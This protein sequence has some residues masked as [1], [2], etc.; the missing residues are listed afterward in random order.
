MAVF[1]TVCRPILVPKDSKGLGLPGLDASCRPSGDRRES[2]QPETRNQ[3]AYIFR[4]GQPCAKHDHDGRKSG[5][6]DAFAAAAEARMTDWAIAATP[7]RWRRWLL[8]ETPQSRLQ[9]R[10]SRAYLS[11]VAFARNPLGMLG[12]VIVAILI[13][14][15]V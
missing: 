13:F 6:V 12:L 11:W 7:P 5:R 14:L 4:A 10:L 15:A 1:R 2:I 8:A 9:A 3:I